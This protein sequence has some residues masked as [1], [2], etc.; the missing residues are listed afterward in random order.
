MQRCSCKRLVN[1]HRSSL[2]EYPLIAIKM[3]PKWL[4]YP[5]S[6]L[7]RC[8]GLQILSGSLGW[9][10]LITKG[11]FTENVFFFSPGLYAVPN[12]L[13]FLALMG[14]M[15]FDS[16]HFNIISCRVVRIAQYASSSMHFW[17]TLEIS[18]VTDLQCCN[19]Y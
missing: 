11:T 7:H 8:W 5:M 15:S 17:Y 19:F 18:F 1:I 3:Y 14:V 12:I 6:M 9:K 13:F 16:Q 10:T 4:A 2:A